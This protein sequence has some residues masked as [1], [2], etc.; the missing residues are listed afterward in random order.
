MSKGI[1]PGVF[2]RWGVARDLPAVVKIEWETGGL[3]GDHEFRKCLARR[4]CIITVAEN[5][6]QEV[7]GFAVYELTDEHTMTVLNLAALGLTPLRALAAKM[8][9]KADDHNRPVLMWKL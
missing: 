6:R 9:D 2:L 7:I 4:N 8:F 1:N 3:W 5:E